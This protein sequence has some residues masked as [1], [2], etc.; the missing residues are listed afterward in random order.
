MTEESNKKITAG[1]VLRRYRED[2]LLEFLNLPLNDVN[3]RGHF[4]DRPIHIAARRGEVPD[5]RALIE[6]GAAINVQGDHDFT[7]LHNAVLHDR[8]DVVKFLLEMG[9]DQ[10][11]TNDDGATALELARIM[12]HADIVTLRWSATEVS[13]SES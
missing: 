10:G 1:D 6:A 11:I 7:A 5:L 3:E 4:G 2:V 12:G 8:T 13:G 9:V